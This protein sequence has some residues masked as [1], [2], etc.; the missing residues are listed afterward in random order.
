MTKT[1]KLAGGRRNYCY[2]E[3][4]FKNHNLIATQPT[5][6]LQCSKL[7]FINC[8][9]D[10]TDRETLFV[11]KLMWATERLTYKL[12]SFSYFDP[13]FLTLVSLWSVIC[14]W[15]LKERTNSYISCLLD[16]LRRRRIMPVGPPKKFSAPNN[17]G[18]ATKIVFGA[19]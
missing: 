12:P 14:S 19:E 10:I 1:L 3:R 15:N 7:V 13:P 17:T 11:T 2:S 8:S 18:W 16:C 4:R 5:I 9:H 6:C